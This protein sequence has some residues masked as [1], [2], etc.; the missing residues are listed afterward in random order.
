MKTYLILPLLI[1]FLFLAS[2]CSKDDNGGDSTSAEVTI[3]KVEPRYDDHIADVHISMKG[4]D[5][6]NVVERGIYWSETPDASKTG[7]SRKESSCSSIANFYT[8]E[9]FRN[10]IY[11][12][13]AFFTYKDPKATTGKITV[14][15]PEVPFRSY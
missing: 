10:K 3:T 7:Q 15:S 5:C 14:Y 11:Y 6:N 4:I 12:V 13:V 9:L 2:A 8:R 1:G